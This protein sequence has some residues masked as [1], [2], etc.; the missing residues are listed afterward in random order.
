MLSSICRF[1]VRLR[2]D[3]PSELTSRFLWP[4]SCSN[5]YHPLLN[6]H[7][8]LD[9][10]SY[11]SLTACL[12]LHPALPDR[13]LS[14]LHTCNKWYDLN[15]VS[16]INISQKLA[17]FWADVMDTYQRLCGRKECHEESTA[18]AEA[19]MGVLYI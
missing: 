12:Q 9:E 3:A 1:D 5:T 10:G 13:F 17:G 6:T 4:N 18:P 7:L 16:S 8:N 11:K 14:L 19:N 15:S 2:P